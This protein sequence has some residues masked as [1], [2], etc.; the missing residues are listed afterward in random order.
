MTIGT[1]TLGT[2]GK[3]GA[4]PSAPLYA[5][6]VSFAGDGNYPTGGTADFEGS[7]QAALASVGLRGLKV[8][9]VISEICGDNKCEY[10]FAND[11]LLVRVIST[12]AEVANAANLSG[13][14]FNLLVLA[15]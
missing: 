3:A 13:T 12:G 6:R 1:I 11:K 7:M 15:Q 9:G 2:D 10:D 8:L 14:T 5:L 4:K